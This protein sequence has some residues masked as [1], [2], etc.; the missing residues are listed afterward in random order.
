MMPLHE[1]PS[2]SYYAFAKEKLEKHDQEIIERTFQHLYNKLFGR[3]WYVQMILNR[4]Y[5]TSVKE[6]SNDLVDNILMEIAE[7]NE[8]T[9]Q[10]FMRLV[11]PG[12][13]KLLKAIASEGKI[14]G[15]LNQSFLGKYN[16]GAASSVKSAAK[17]LVE[18]ELLLLDSNGFYQIYD[19]FFGIWLR[20]L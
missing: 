3:T 11:T 18:K 14:G 2:S 15:L 12:Q 4:L 7:E 20:N 5:E 9:F 6:I 16:L 8:A 1:I 17:A 13:G 10:T 19:R